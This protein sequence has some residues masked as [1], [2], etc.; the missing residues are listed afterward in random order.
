[1]NT[2]VKLPS[3]LTSVTASLMFNNGDVQ[4]TDHELIPAGCKRLQCSVGGV[5]SMQVDGRLPI[6]Q[7]Q[8]D[9]VIHT[10]TEN[11]GQVNCNSLVHFFFEGRMFSRWIVTDITSARG[12]LHCRKTRVS[13]GDQLAIC[14]LHSIYATA[15][16]FPRTQS[17]L[18]HRTSS[19]TVIRICDTGIYVTRSRGGDTLLRQGYLDKQRV[20]HTG[21]SR[22]PHKYSHFCGSWSATV[23]GH[24]E[25]HAQ[26]FLR[27]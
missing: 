5:Q 6:G 1:V 18:Y 24:T 27:G 4:S 13:C 26:F 22:K 15:Y 3:S 12:T 9:V 20:S 16:R 19:S 14:G 7:R 2:N 21:E 17:L 10:L 23:C 11:I 25:R 8:G